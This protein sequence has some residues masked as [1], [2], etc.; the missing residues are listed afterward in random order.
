VARRQ[1]DA[2]RRHEIEEGIVR[3]RHRL[4]HLADDRL[5]LMRAGDGEHAGMRGAD[6][7]GLNPEAAGDDDLAVL[8]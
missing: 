7:I 8:R 6:A 4:V 2:L 5:I 3:A 1:R